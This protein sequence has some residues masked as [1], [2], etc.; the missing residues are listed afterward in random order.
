MNTF[1][2]K[3]NGKYKGDCRKL[4][5]FSK[6]NFLKKVLYSHEFLSALFT[7][8]KKELQISVSLME[9]NLKFKCVEG[10]MTS[11]PK[12]EILRYS[13]SFIKLSRPCKPWTVEPR[14]VLGFE[15]I[16]LFKSWYYFSAFNKLVD[17]GPLPLLE[18][19]LL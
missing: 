19:A 16:V 10:E 14:G 5:E 12:L 15:F 2:D 17:G 8:L 7:L 9:I 3:E 18:H 6:H 1:Q 11:S 13:E 4:K